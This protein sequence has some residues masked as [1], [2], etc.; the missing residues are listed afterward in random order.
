MADINIKI[1]PR[2]GPNG[3]PL[4]YF[5]DGM[6]RAPVKL[7]IPSGSTYS[8]TDRCRLVHQGT[9]NFQ[10]LYGSSRIKQVVM[11][12]G[13]STSG[14]NHGELHAEFLEPTQKLVLGKAGNSGS[15][16]LDAGEI[17]NATA[18]GSVLITAEASIYF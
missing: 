15:A 16:A 14:L 8:T 2:L 18:L 17:A 5:E 12:G 7:T 4:V 10:E 6:R 1:T 9:G 3:Q 13:F 11:S